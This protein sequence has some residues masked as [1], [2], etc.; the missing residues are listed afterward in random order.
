MADRRPKRDMRPQEDREFDQK[1]IDIARVTRVMAGGK[2]MRFR[3][4]VVIGDHIARLGYGVGKGSDVTIAIN[5]AVSRAKKDLVTIPIIKGTIP[6][7][8]H[9]KYKAAR[10][11]LKPAPEGTGVMAGGAVRSALE[12]S[13]IG[14]VV[15]KIY[16]S[17][18]KINNIRALFCALRD[19]SATAQRKHLMIAP[20]K[21]EKKEDVPPVLQKAGAVES[22]ETK[23]AQDE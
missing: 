3:A 22:V 19:V 2:R 9:I 23:V 13:G 8:V 17:K 7:E 4:C 20:L 15:A 1:L 6:H 18:S 11:L 16:G 21:K 12:L 10:L 5:K 14:N